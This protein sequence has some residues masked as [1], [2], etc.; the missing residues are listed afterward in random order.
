[1][2]SNCSTRRRS[3]LCSPPRPVKAFVRWGQ[4][5]SRPMGTEWSLETRICTAPWPKEAA[6]PPCVLRPPS[7]ALYH[8]TASA[9]QHSSGRRVV[10]PGPPKGVASRQLSWGSV[11][12]GHA[13]AG[14][15]SGQQGPG[16][17]AGWEKPPPPSITKGAWGTEV[18]HGFKA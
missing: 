8:L 4:S 17:G 16:W 7:Q 2:A 5:W 13:W 6:E 3:Q 14:R 9:A 15:P 12:A 1:M 10:F 18:H 11:E